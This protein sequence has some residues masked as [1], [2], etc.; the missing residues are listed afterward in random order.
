M[1]LEGV[2][3]KADHGKNPCPFG[4]EVPDGFVAG[5]VEAP[6]GQ[7]NRHAAA[8][9]EELK[10]ALDEEDVAPDLGLPLAVLG[11]LA[12]SNWCRMRESLMSPA[13]G[14]LVRSTSKSK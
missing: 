7:H 3:V 10:V 1:G 2:P 4:D 9:P 6:L 8:G 5:V 12:S 14:G 13:K 11:F